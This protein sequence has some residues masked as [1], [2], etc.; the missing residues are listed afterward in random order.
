MFKH[1]TFP[2]GIST[3]AAEYKERARKGD[4]W[5]NELFGLGSAKPTGTFKPTKEITR[6]SPY[7]NR[8]TLNDRNV[9]IRASVD[10]GYQGNENPGL[11]G[12]K[13][14][15]DYGSTG[16]NKLGEYTLNSGQLSGA[17]R[18]Y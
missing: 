14:S 18:A 8:A 6:K 7:R 10:S 11:F 2:G 13:M 5:Q 1:I 15:N 16:N 3:K 17:P 9:G 4:S 12:T